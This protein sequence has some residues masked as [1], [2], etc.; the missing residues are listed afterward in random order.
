MNHKADEAYMAKMCH[1]GWAVTSLVEGIWTVEPCKPGQYTFCVC[2]LRGK[3]NAEVERSETAMIYNEVFT[4]ST[5]Q[6][7]I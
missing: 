4:T 2:Y 1:E 5:S 6:V 7:F 3:S